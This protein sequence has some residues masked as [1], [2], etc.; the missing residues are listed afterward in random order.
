MHLNNGYEIERKFLIEYPNVQALRQITGSSFASLSQF[1][2][3]TGGRVR[4]IE[5]SEGTVYIKTVKQHIT[6]I[7]RKETEWEITKEEYEKELNNIKEG[8]HVIEKV[9]YKIPSGEHTLE[10]DLFP[11]WNDRAFLEVELKEETEEFI[12]PSF[13]KII[14]E[15]TSDKRYRNSA[16]AVEIINEEL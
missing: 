5:V 3:K 6:D 8:T 13:I 16:L 7:K 1:Y 9:R 4:K 14:K 2:L 10:I 12:I 11:F 15:V